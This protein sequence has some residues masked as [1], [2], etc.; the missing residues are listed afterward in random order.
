M[1]HTDGGSRTRKTED[2]DMTGEGTESQRRAPD[3]R[4]GGDAPRGPRGGNETGE[5]EA[6]AA[7]APEEQ[8]EARGEGD[9]ARGEEERRP[10]DRDRGER[11][12]R[13]DAQFSGDKMNLKELKEKRISELTRMAR[14]MGVEGAAGMRK[15]DLIFALL[16]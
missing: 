2:M 13:A 15:Q 12:P 1:A 16:Q 6:E 5:P 14:E 8:P 9:A 7:A 10:R 3:R 11:E 4:R